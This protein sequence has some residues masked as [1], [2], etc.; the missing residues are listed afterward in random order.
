M[1]LSNPTWGRSTR[2][3][4]L[5]VPNQSQ[6]QKDV[7]ASPFFRWATSQSVYTMRSQR[8]QSATI[9]PNRS[10]PSGRFRPLADRPLRRGKEQQPFKVGV[11]GSAADAGPGQRGFG[12]ECGVPVGAAGP[13]PAPHLCP[14]MT[15]APLAL[16]RAA[17]GR[18]RG[19]L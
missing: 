12:S 2:F 18:G 19:I 6:V 15:R 9:R 16:E 8:G 13:A 17:D 7:S 11:L 1:G 4:R 14:L 10:V 5:L 3:E